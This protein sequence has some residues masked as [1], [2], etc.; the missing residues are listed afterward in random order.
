[1]LGLRTN[2]GLLRRVLA[3]DAFVAGDVHT[4]FL[5]EHGGALVDAAP[6]ETTVAAVAA[7][8]SAVQARRSRP[9]TPKGRAGAGGHPG[10]DGP[11]DDRDAGVWN[12]LTGWRLDATDA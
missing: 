4:G 9:A 5:A 12:R 10:A 1:M 11:L 2:I 8:V 7:A 3:H 6:D